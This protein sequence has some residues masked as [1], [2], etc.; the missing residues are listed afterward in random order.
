MRLRL[1]ALLSSMWLTW[2]WVIRVAIAEGQLDMAD[3]DNELVN[4]GQTLWK[5]KTTEDVLREM[6]SK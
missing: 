1:G 5:W 3:N 6:G 4:P 2:T